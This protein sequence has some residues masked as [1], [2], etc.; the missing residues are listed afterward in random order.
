MPSVA[1]H[2]G[3]LRCTLLKFAFDDDPF[4]L[5]KSTLRT[6]TCLLCHFLLLLSH[7]AYYNT[8]LE[9]MTRQ[10]GTQGGEMSRS[11]SSVALPRTSGQEFWF[12]SFNVTILILGCR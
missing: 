10:P 5:W 9:V 7:L 8:L 2:Q 4:G 11:R 3:D 1:I 6:M 12:C